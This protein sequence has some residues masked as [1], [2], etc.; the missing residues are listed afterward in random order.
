MHDNVLRAT[1]I[2]KRTM[3]AYSCHEK[4]KNDFY[5]YGWDRRMMAN[6][7]WSLQREFPNN[8]NKR[9]RINRRQ[10][11]KSFSFRDKTLDLITS[12]S[13]SSYLSGIGSGFDLDAG[14]PW[15]SCSSVGSWLHIDLVIWIG[16][17][18]VSAEQNPSKTF[19][20]QLK[21]R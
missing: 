21:R 20:L 1:A 14:Q 15:N 19:R 6:Y 3:K 7:F 2:H 9:N 8:L 4:R 10:C 5:I 11:V 13:S 16:A 18:K 17:Q 12:S